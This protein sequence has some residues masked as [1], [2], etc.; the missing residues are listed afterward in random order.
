MYC[1]IIENLID[2]KLKVRTDFQ[3]QWVPLNIIPSVHPLFMTLSG[4]FHYPG[5]YI[6]VYMPY[7]NCAC[8]Y[9]PRADL[10]RASGRVYLCQR[11]TEASTSTCLSAQSAAVELISRECAESSLFQLY[12]LSTC[13]SRCVAVPRLWCYANFMTISGIRFDIN[14]S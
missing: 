9:L 14:R 7:K 3:I 4:I 5:P 11:L 8:A 6:H 2:V 1:K 10:P 12:L 13:C